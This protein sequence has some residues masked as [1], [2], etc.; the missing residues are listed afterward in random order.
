[1]AREAEEQARRTAVAELERQA[2]EEQAQRAALAELEREAAREAEPVD[3]PQPQR[4]LASRSDPSE[5]NGTRATES[6]E[7]ENGS[8][9]TETPLEEEAPTA[10]LE[11]PIYR[12]FGRT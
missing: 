12:W 3:E 5:T 9:A 4:A 7:S 6:H 8:G 2:A 1:V 10:N 11:L